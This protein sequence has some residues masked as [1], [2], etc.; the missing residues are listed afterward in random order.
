M[1]DVW[2]SALEEPTAT[3]VMAVLANSAD[4]DGTNCFPG[5][6][7]IARRTRVS[8]RT[9]IRTIQELEHG[10]WLWVV[11]R[12]LGQGNRTEYRLNV[13]RLH[14]QAEQTREEERRKRC[15]HV[16]FRSD[17]TGKRKGDTGTAKGDTRAAKGD[18][19]VAPLFVLPVSDPSGYPTPPNP[20]PRE[21][22]R[23]LELERAVDPV[24][25]ALGIDSKSRRRRRPVKAAIANA[26]EKGELPATIALEII[27]AVRDQAKLHLEGMVK[28]QFGLEKFLG[29]GIWRDRDRWAWDTAEMRQRAAASVGSAR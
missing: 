17:K 14:E 6:R 16:T 13:Q 4:D 11:Q 22:V 19:D 26:A 9:V 28:F 3:H 5:T 27:A 18:I 7:L 21:G 25:S 15:H 29:L 8:E 12:G 2:D 23:E 24:C 1:A 20:L 10:G